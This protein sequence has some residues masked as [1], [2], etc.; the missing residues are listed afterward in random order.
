M[1]ARAALSNC[2]W[3]EFPYEPPG[4]SLQARDFFLT[5]PIAPDSEGYLPVPN[6]PGLGVDIDEES[7][8][9]YTVSD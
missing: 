2:H 8:Q 7:I 6:K 9:R 3:A 1:D 5:E 4:W